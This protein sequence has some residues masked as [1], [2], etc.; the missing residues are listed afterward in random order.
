MDGDKL[1]P[2]E[3]FT[4]SNECDTCAGAPHSHVCRY[5]KQSITGLECDAYSGLC[6]KCH[7]GGKC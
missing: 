6:R 4:G 7:V 5:C 2:R 3:A 1:D